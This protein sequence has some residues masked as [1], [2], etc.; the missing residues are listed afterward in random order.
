MQNGTRCNY[1]PSDPS[2][3]ELCL[4]EKWGLIW[5]IIR[6]TFL[7]KRFLAIII[8]LCCFLITDKHCICPLPVVSSTWEFD[9]FQF[10]VLEVSHISYQVRNEFVFTSYILMFFR[11]KLELGSIIFKR[12]IMGMERIPGA[13]DLS[14][15]LERLNIT[16]WL[17][18]LFAC[19]LLFIISTPKLVVSRNFL[20]IRIVLSC[21]YQLIFYFVK[22]STW[23]WRLPYAWSF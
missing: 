1:F 4:C 21:F 16:T 6:G 8:L 5:T 17:S 18:F 20:S 7:F 12:C 2:G 10:L 11:I 15:I 13:G 23:I 22:F 9:L 19:H 14:E 3:A